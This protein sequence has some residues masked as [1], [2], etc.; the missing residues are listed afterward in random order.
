MPK[1]STFCE[2]RKSLDGVSKKKKKNRWSFKKLSS[3]KKRWEISKRNCRV[4]ELN[5]F[6]SNIELENKQKK[7]ENMMSNSTWF[8]AISQASATLTRKAGLKII[9]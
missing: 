7:V 1:K 3:I 2:T 8:S 5:N 9:P 6:C 4:K